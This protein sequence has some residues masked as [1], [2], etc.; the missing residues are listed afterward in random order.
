MTTMRAK[1]GP[2]RNGNTLV[3]VSLILVP[4]FGLL[5]GILD[6]GFATFLRSTMQHAVREGARYAVTYQTQAGMCQDAS[7]KSIVQTASMG[8][9]P[10]GSSYVQVRYFNPTTFGEI[11]TGGNSPGN[12]VEIS[13][14]NYKYSWLA[15]IF[16]SSTPLWI[17]VRSSDRMEGL[18]GGMQPPCR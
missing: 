11:T 7:I 13:I 3:E 9:V 15:P 18:P 6:F 17:N 1:Y 12:I 10:S 16:W 4:L 5:F 14:E 2:G 8:F